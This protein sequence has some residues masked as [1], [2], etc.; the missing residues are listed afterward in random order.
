MEGIALKSASRNDQVALRGVRLCSQLV[1]SGHK[2]TVEQT[3]VNLEK[4]AIEAVYTF[5][6]PENAAVC[7]FEIVTGDRVLTGEVEESE[8]AEEAY[9]DAVS[10]GHG[11]YLLEQHR[12]DIFTINVGNLKPQQAVTIRLTY[13]AE[14]EATDSVIRLAFPTTVAPRYV[15]ATGTDPLQAMIEGE[16]INPPH[17]L[18]VPYGLTLEMDVDLGLPVTAIESSSHAIEAQMDEEGRG[19]VRLAAGITELDRDIVLQITLG[20]EPTPSAQA[21][22]G[23]G[24]DTFVA[25]TLQPQFDDVDDIPAAPQEVVFVLDCSGSMTGDSIRQAGRAL[26]LCLRSLSERDR[27][28]ICRFGSTFEMMSRRSLS[29][30]AK[31]LN[32]AVKYIR[33]VGADLGGTELFAP[34]E[35]ILKTPTTDGRPRQIVLLT[36]GQISNE[37]AVIDLARRHNRDHRI[38]TFGIG[39]ACSAHLVKSLARVTGGA[40][41]FVS[42]GER[43]EDK[44]LRTFCRLCSPMAT[45]VAIDWGDAEVIAASPDVPPAFEGDSLMLLGRVIGQAPSHCT[46]SIKTSGGPCEWRIPIP[47]HASQDNTIASLWARRRIR[48]LEDVSGEEHWSPRATRRRNKELIRLSK[49]FRILCSQTSFIALEHRSVKE[50]TDGV[51]AFR[52]VPVQLA[53][54]WHG[55]DYLFTGLPGY[56]VR[57]EAADTEGFAKHLR[58]RSAKEE[59]MVAGRKAPVLSDREQYRQV[60]DDSLVSESSD[61]LI[62]ILATQQADGSFEWRDS[63][64]NVLRENGL[65]P[66][67]CHAAFLQAFTEAGFEFKGKDYVGAIVTLFILVLLATQYADRK[68]IWSRAYLKGVRYAAQKFGISPDEMESWLSSPQVAAQ[69]MAKPVPSGERPTRREV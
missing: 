55:I 38:F 8:K 17:V 30:S 53:R 64:D 52:R 33:R 57:S 19:T 66:V 11:G 45:D 63:F 40:A 46:V 43:I 26:E 3:F 13:V 4:R 34:L 6:L 51:P 61:S 41:E 2:T 56:T 24:G 36:D 68:D 54:G 60:R 21:C 5:P 32:K 69:V 39:S 9:D 20:R 1:A 16:Q 28:N 48:Y 65:Q 49:A 58:A 23:P 62:E 15:T 47:A 14:L 7:H 44:V 12:P 31:T 18:S 50:R 27:F 37:Q 22:S 25:V 29:Y 10:R 35:A 42:E 67:Q 59:G